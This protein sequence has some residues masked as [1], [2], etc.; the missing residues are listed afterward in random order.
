MSTKETGF[1]TSLLSDLET[2]MLI[3]SSNFKCW[4]DAY[5][6]KV[7][8][9]FPGVTKMHRWQLDYRRLDDSFFRWVVRI[10]KICLY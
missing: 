7:L 5:N 8:A 10:A 2:D 9:K 1:E 6:A 3:Q 4:A